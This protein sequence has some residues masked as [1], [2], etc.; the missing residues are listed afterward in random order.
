MLRK[1]KSP[2]FAASRHNIGGEAL[3]KNSLSRSPV[4]VVNQRSLLSRLSTSEYLYTNGVSTILHLQAQGAYRPQSPCPVQSSQPAVQEEMRAERTAG[5]LPRLDPMNMTAALSSL[6]LHRANPPANSTAEQEG[7]AKGGVIGGKGRYSVL[8]NKAME[9]FNQDIDEVFHRQTLG[10]TTQQQGSK[11]RSPSPIGGRPFSKTADLSHIVDVARRERGRTPVE[12]FC[13]VLKHIP[14]LPLGTY[15]PAP[16]QFFG[17]T[18]SPRTM[19]SN[20]DNNRKTSLGKENYPAQAN[21]HD[22]RPT[23]G[24]K[25]A[26]IYHPTPSVSSTHT[27][28]L[29]PH[30]HSNLPIPAKPSPH[31]ANP[32]L[33]PVSTSNTA[34]GSRVPPLTAPVS[35]VQSRRCSNNFTIFTKEESTSE[36]GGGHHERPRDAV[37]KVVCTFQPLSTITIAPISSCKMTANNSLSNSFSKDYH[38][39]KLAALHIPPHQQEQCSPSSSRVQSRSNSKTRSNS[40]PN[41]NASPSKFNVKVPSLQ[42][43]E[44]RTPE[45]KQ[46]KVDPGLERLLLKGRELALR[47]EMDQPGALTFENRFSNHNSVGSKGDH[48]K[49]GSKD[50][51]HD[52]L[53]DRLFGIDKSSRM[54]SPEVKYLFRDTHTFKMKEY[55]PEG[56]DFTLNQFDQT[57]GAIDMSK[58]TELKSIF[59]KQVTHIETK[60]KDLSIIRESRT[61]AELEKSAPEK[62]KLSSHIHLETEQEN[63]HYSNGSADSEVVDEGL[64]QALKYVQAKVKEINNKTDRTSSDPT[65]RSEEGTLDLMDIR[66]RLD[67]IL[68]ES[69]FI[70][71]AQKLPED[72]KKTINSG[73]I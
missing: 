72:A 47:I 11:S 32:L 62:S 34:M 51:S 39:N 5:L 22:E 31:C 44:K 55:S 23:F 61:E 37:N 58:Q 8:A 29:Q 17:K 40:I 10:S 64:Q 63:N 7:A 65:P 36:L 45:L 28:P 59:E 53:H 13:N 56:Y 48:Q 70:E 60:F 6:G 43:G 73:Q 71:Q 18:S 1:D 16:S 57:G 24:A 50:Q 20:G 9:G 21:F 33:T 54:G 69:I 66:N 42:I 4:P 27:Q 14:T 25:A 19:T 2:D 68:K 38:P 3:R 12:T 41:V 30:K 67:R 52:S 35:H 49:Y 46:E 15:K 26:L